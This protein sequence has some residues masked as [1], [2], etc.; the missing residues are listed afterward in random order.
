[1]NLHRHHHMPTNLNR[2]TLVSVEKLSEA[3]LDA[4][5]AA[6][7]W[8]QRPVKPLPPM[9]FEPASYVAGMSRI[10]AAH[11]A[12]EI[13]D[14]YEMTATDRVLRAWFWR[15]VLAVFLVAGAAVVAW[16]L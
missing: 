7:N 9:P 11:A 14:D 8:P 3:D 16:L 12:S 5:R 1:M 13:D 4:A 6:K 15:V 2:P 10:E